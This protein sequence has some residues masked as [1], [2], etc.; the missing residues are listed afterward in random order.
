MEAH[1]GLGDDCLPD[2]QT[3]RK[4]LNSSLTLHFKTSVDPVWPL[5]SFMTYKTM[6]CKHTKNYSC[7]SLK[8]G[9]R[10]ERPWYHISIL[11]FTTVAPH[12]DC[13][14]NLTI[15]GQVN[16]NIHNKF[17]FLQIW[18]KTIFFYIGVLRHYILYLVDTVILW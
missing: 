5:T 12:N 8:W 17:I 1:P 13:L 10:N 9:P 18:S 6:Q 14:I 3:G 4:Y 2:P 11:L 16:N 7:L 15:T